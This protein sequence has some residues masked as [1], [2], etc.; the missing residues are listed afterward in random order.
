VSFIV[1]IKALSIVQRCA[2][3]GLLIGA[4]VGGV[5][6]LVV[7]VDVHAATAWFAILELGTPASAVGGVVGGL[8]GWGMRLRALRR[9]GRGNALNR[10]T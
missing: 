2:V 8:V 3:V 6:G 9:T 7:G 10:R 5:V 4:A 1:E